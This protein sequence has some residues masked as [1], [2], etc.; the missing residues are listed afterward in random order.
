MTRIG[1]AAVALAMAFSAGAAVAADETA[2][3]P[4][5]YYLRLFREDPE[6]LRKIYLQEVK[7][8]HES[9]QRS[10]E[11]Y[12]D[13][14]LVNAAGIKVFERARKWTHDQL[15]A[16][17]RKA[18]KLVAEGKL[19]YTDERPKK[20][21]RSEKGK[22]H[23]LYDLLELDIK[24]PERDP[25]LGAFLEVVKTAVPGELTFVQ[26]KMIVFAPLDHEVYEPFLSV[27][28][29][30]W[31]A[32]NETQAGSMLFAYQ[33]HKSGGGKSNSRPAVEKPCAT[34]KDPALEIMTLRA[35]GVKV[36][37][38]A[39]KPPTT[40]KDALA[41]L[42]KSAPGILIQVKP[43]KDGTTPAVPQVRVED[44][45]VYET[46]MLLCD[47]VDY[48]VRITSRGILAEPKD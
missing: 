44:A 38:F 6:S 13:L 45:S 1:K 35:R 14:G 15:L 29:K 30:V 39:V 7:R 34:K 22:F 32:G 42:Q 12:K 10:A 47:T 16:R 3:A 27:Y 46:A 25:D 2:P 19:V 9:G 20:G 48:S 24:N 40:L 28:D 18:A 11:Y 21:I 41:K 4:Y 36:Q 17:A 33:F 8:C 31:K 43:L 26:R 23:M 37:S 5:D